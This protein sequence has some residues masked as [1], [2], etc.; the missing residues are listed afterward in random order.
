MLAEEAKG[1][2]KTA[3][4]ALLWLL[5]GQEFT[6]IGMKG[7]LADDKKELSVSF[8]E[9]YEST[10]KP[11]HNFLVKGVFAVRIVVYYYL[12]LD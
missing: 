1:N 11:F 3:T 6:L 9:G 8:T 4:Q 10:L 2:D 12:L 5:R 7:T